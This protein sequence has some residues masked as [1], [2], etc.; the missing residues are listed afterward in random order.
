MFTQRGGAPLVKA[1]MPACDIV[2]R[3][4]DTRWC[5]PLGGYARRENERER[6]QRKEERE[7]E[8]DKGESLPSV[9]ETPKRPH[10]NTFRICEGLRPSARHRAQRPGP[11][12][13]N[14]VACGPCFTIIDMQK[15]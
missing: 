15:L 10:V 1:P 8:G 3:A 14:L 9:L 6:A 7:R 12:R 4:S 5:D 13:L 2:D 11:L